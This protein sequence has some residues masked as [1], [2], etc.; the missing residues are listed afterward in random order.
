MFRTQLI[1]G[2]CARGSFL[3]PILNFRALVQR[4]ISRGHF[5]FSSEMFAVYLSRKKL[6]NLFTP[7]GMISDLPPA[8]P[9]NHPTIPTGE[10]NA[11]KP[12][13]ASHKKNESKCILHAKTGWSQY[14]AWLIFLV[15]FWEHF[16]GK[17]FCFQW[18]ID[19]TER[20]GGFYFKNVVKVLIYA[21]PWKIAKWSGVIKINLQGY[22]VIFSNIEG[23]CIFLD[24]YAWKILLQFC[25]TCLVKPDLPNP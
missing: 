8:F 17:V 24:F 5:L 21:E 6:P 14:F 3:M 19:F 10:T 13:A 12:C 22:H 2:Q 18:T 25:L 23:Y 9:A 4:K 11:L 20:L 16:T 15:C 1:I 7:K